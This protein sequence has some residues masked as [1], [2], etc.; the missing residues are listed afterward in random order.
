MIFNSPYIPASNSARL[1]AQTVAI[2]DDPTKDIQFYLAQCCVYVCVGGGG[3]GQVSIACMGCLELVSLA[4]A[5]SK[6]K[7][8]SNAIPFD[9]RT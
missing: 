2:D 8:K 4:V 1:P 5:R 7:L 6:S 3:T 9:S